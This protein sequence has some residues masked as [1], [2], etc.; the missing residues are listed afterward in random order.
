MIDGVR[1]RALRA[2]GEM[3]RIERSGLD[4]DAPLIGAAELVLSGVIAD[5][6]RAEGRIVGGHAVAGG[7]SG[8]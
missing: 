5:P 6:A 8:R 3:A 7:G 2:P 1:L 4:S